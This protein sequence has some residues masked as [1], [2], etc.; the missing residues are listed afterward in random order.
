MCVPR[1]I[2]ERIFNDSSVDYRG[3]TYGPNENAYK[4]DRIWSVLS[5]GGH[6]VTVEGRNIFSMFEDA[7]GT[8]DANCFTFTAVLV[9]MR[10][11][12]FDAEVTAVPYMTYSL[13]GVSTTVNGNSITESVN[14]AANSD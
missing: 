1:P 8:E 11:E 10:P 7:D 13:D 9:G 3:N 2:P 14:G 5:A 6:S 4:I 12:N